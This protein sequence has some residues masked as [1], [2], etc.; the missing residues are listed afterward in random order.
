MM[1]V[2]LL[3]DYYK[4]MTQNFS[5][6]KVRRKDEKESILPKFNYKRPNMVDYTHMK[7]VKTVTKII[8]VII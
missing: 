6:K 1:V 2:K 7:C 4:C 3:I 8:F 5:H